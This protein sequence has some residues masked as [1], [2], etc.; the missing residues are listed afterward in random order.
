MS[1]K[2][3]S[4]KLDRHLDMATAMTTRCIQACKFTDYG[5]RFFS[6]KLTALRTEDEGYVQ[7]AFIK[8][9]RDHTHLLTG[10]NTR[11]L[12]SN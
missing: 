3:I 8:K 6:K 11:R 10:S 4:R 1:Q 2:I 7:K 9:Y 5:V 12:A